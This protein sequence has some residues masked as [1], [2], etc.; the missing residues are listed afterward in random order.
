MLQ[1]AWLYSSSVAYLFAGS[2]HLRGLPCLALP[3]FSLP[4][5]ALP[6]FTAPTDGL[7]PWPLAVVT[8]VTTGAYNEWMDY[9]FVLQYNTIVPLPREQG[10]G[11]RVRRASGTV[12]QGAEQGWPRLQEGAS[13]C[14]LGEISRRSTPGDTALFLHFFT[15]FFFFGKVC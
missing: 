2:P 15:S 14:G 10:H 6:C 4:C 7:A 1:D 11:G 9:C 8:L 12:L 13:V 5:L 3:C